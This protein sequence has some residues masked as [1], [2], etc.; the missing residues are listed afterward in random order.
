MSI[1]TNLVE[2]FNKQLKEVSKLEVG[3]DKYKV[4]VEGVTKL[5]DRIL[6]IEKLEQSEAEIGG[7][8]EAQQEELNIKRDQ[9]NE[10]KKDRWIKYGMEG[11]KIV[12]GAGLAA[13][14]FISSMH[15]EKEGTLTTEGGRAALKKLFGFMK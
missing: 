7:K 3:S 2:E 11:V 13:W 1:K 9:M 10:D 8:W 6:E 12:G 14:A 5:A 4:A 15:F